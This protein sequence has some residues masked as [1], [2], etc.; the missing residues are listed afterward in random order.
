MLWC[1]RC[2][3]RTAFL[4][5]SK[6]EYGWNKR[7]SIHRPV[8]RDKSRGAMRYGGTPAGPQ[9]SPLGWLNA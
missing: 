5:L 9:A 4:W 2:R 1:V 3:E 6:V 7:G 8:S